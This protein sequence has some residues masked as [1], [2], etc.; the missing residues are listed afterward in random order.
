MAT[1]SA[2][3]RIVSLIASS[4][5]IVCSLGLQDWLVGRSHEC[6]WPAAVRALPQCTEPKFTLSGTSYEIDQR[7]K[8]ILQEGLSVY[9][10][11]ATALDALRPEVIITQTQCEVCAVSLRD[12]EAAVCQLIGSRPQIV[13]LNPNCLA[14][15]WEDIR[16]IAVGCGVAARGEELVASL[17]GSMDAIA[18]RAQSAGHRPSVAYIEWIDPLM[19]GG[20]WMPELVE[21]AGG[22][23]LFGTAGKHSPL[24]SWEGLVAA[25]PEILFVAPCGFE[26]A[27][28]LQEMPHLAEKK[29][30]PALRAVQ[31][32]RV[33]VADGNQYFNRPG[34][35]LCESL[36]I[37]AEVIHPELVAAT[38][39]GS[40]WVRYGEEGRGA[41]K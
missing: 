27:R 34:P 3:K 26:I 21:L 24:Q 25:D 13:S 15:V 41:V 29:E 36:Q 5:E 9:H 37:L 33:F 18:A 11:S 28:T 20:N 7:I 8:A 4:T 17:K 23:S 10:V 39:H 14:D 35:R 19:T 12:V 31:S 30:W 32:G 1:D 2:P 6:D 40:G 22:H 38:L 16:R